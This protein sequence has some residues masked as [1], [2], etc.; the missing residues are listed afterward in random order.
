MPGRPSDCVE[1]MRICR[2]TAALGR[3]RNITLGSHS[4]GVEGTR[5]GINFRPGGEPARTSKG[6]PSQSRALWTSPQA[7]A[8]DARLGAP[9][10]EPSGRS[11]SSLNPIRRVDTHPLPSAGDRSMTHKQP[12]GK[13]YTHSLVVA[14]SS[15]RDRTE[16][17]RVGRQISF[18]ET[19]CDL[20]D[21]APSP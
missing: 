2:K 6:R 17:W 19:H 13:R 21:A 4:R 7:S 9:G 11:A 5:R 3:D 14:E 16:S 10:E 15:F 8:D 1:S 12:S 20:K 18:L